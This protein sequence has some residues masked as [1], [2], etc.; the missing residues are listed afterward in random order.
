MRVRREGDPPPPL[1][2]GMPGGMPGG[3]T[4]GLPGGS[5]ASKRRTLGARRAA[6]LASEAARAE[7][8]S[9]H[10][11]P[12]RRADRSLTVA[13]SLRRDG[14]GPALATHQA[15]QAGPLLGV[16]GDQ[17]PHG[18]GPAAAGQPRDRPPTVG[19]SGGDVGRGRGP[20]TGRAAR[21]AWLL[22]RRA[23][24]ARLVTHH[25]GPF[26]VAVEDRNS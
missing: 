8:A 9:A 1:A 2:G 21:A 14:G 19:A 10:G 11:E 7:G 23:G 24:V 25:E 20:V 17:Q 18:G 3:M 26:F 5:A 22:D 13:T 12:S 15:A 16:R 4:G 6:E